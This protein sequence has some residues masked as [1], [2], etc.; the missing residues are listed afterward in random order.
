MVKQKTFSFFK[1]LLVVLAAV[2]L[3]SGPVYCGQAKSMVLTLP[4]ETLLS[5]VQQ[6]LPL[7]IP[8]QGHRLQGDIVL[9]SLDRLSIHNNTITVAGTLSGRNLLLTT[10][11]AGQDFQVQVG[12]V[13]LPI[14]CSLKTRFASKQR[15][16]YV[17]PTFPDSANGGDD[18]TSMLGALADREYELD[19]DRLKALNID[20]G[21]ETIP[22]ALDPIR[23]DA[24]NN[25]LTLYLLPRVGSK[26]ASQQ[27][28]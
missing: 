23:I 20:L 19:L 17:T 28:R 25:K 7:P 13:R 16:L 26:H 2:F 3:P 18:L 12:Q 14:K 8:A 6:M 10:R 4:A 24:T 22:V 5:A 1:V 15:K 27:R 21:N 9:E 11:L